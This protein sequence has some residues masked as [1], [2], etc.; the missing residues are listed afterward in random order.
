MEEITLPYIPFF[1]RGKGFLISLL[2]TLET[3]QRTNQLELQLDRSQEVQ[4]LEQIL[5]RPLR[6]VK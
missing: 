6:T 5:Y 4:I 3:R 1:R 2:T